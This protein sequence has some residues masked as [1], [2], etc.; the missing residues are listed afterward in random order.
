MD[1]EFNA[2]GA[3]RKYCGACEYYGVECEGCG[4]QGGA[5]V[6]GECDIYR[7]CIEEWGFEFCGECDEFPCEMYSK[8]I[9]HPSF[10]SRE[11]LEESISRRLVIGTEA[12]LEEQS[13]GSTE[14][15]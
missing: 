7:C 12:W 2:A 9:E 3:C 14:T 10:P 15:S 13:L 4:A 1:E 6:W 8:A 5:P 11:M